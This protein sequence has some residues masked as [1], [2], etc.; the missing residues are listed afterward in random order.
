MFLTVH[1]QTVFPTEYVGTFMIYL[2]IN[3]HFPSA[4][5]TLV[6]ASKPKIKS[7]LAWLPT[8]C[9]SPHK[10]LIST[11]VS[12]YCHI[13]ISWCESR[14]C[15]SFFH[16]VISP[17]HHVSITACGDLESKAFVSIWMIKELTQIS[18]KLLKCLKSGKGETITQTSWQSQTHVVF[19]LRR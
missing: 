19:P 3:V 10:I 18:W 9:F 1:I 2:H 12:Q 17:V 11:E 6:T 8:F 13:K 16:L 15:F 7:I 5:C 4:S 14:L